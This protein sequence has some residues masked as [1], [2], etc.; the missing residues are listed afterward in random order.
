[1][2]KLNFSLLAAAVLAGNVMADSSTL[3]DAF[4]NGK[5]S[6]E[7]SAYFTQADNGGATAD[8]GYSLGSVSLGFET[9]TMGGVKAAV[10]FM[11]NTEFSEKEDGDYS[12]G[13][14]PKAIMNIANLSYANDAVTVILGRQAIDLEW[15]GDYHEAAVAA[16][17]AIPNATIIL[18]YTDKIN[19]SAND[20]ALE[21][22]SK[23]NG[24]KGAYVADVSYKVNDNV[25]LGAYYMDAPDVF[26]AAGGKVEL[27]MGELGAVAK[28]AATSED[29]MA[30]DGDIAAIDLSYTTETFGVNGGYITTDN[31]AGAGSL[32]ALGDNINPFDS[33]NQVY[34]AD[35]DTWYVGASASV[36]G[37]DLGVLYGST[38]YDNGGVEET[39]KEFNFTVEKEVY[40]NTTLSLLVAD[41]DA[42]ATNDDSTYYSAQLIYSF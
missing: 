22:F 31:T 21:D 38:D 30:N 40:K 6:G 41:I 39:E 42:E 33:G 34:G 29:T 17:T 37:F 26:S 2:K 19:T 25:A 8:S 14:E 9:D 4:K 24:T 5:T 23:I 3:E 32:P 20:G 28:Y 1:M 10:G 18:G 12:A 13:D 36:A 11:A 35:A 7:L 15:I 16:I 27:T